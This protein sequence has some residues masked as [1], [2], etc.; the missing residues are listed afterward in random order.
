MNLDTCTAPQRRV[1][2]TLNAPLMVSAGAG[3]GKTFTL[4]QRVAY[5]LSPNGEGAAYLDSVDELLAITFTTKAAAELKS[6]IKG[7]LLSEGLAEEALKVDGAWVSTIH[8]MASRILREHALEIGIDPAFEVVG[9]VEAARLLDAATEDVAAAMEAGADPALAAL[10]GRE[11]LRGSAPGER[12]ALDFARAVLDRVSALPGGFDALVDTGTEVRPADLVRRALAA[13]EAMAAYAAGWSK[14]SKKKVEFADRLAGAIEGAQAWLAGARGDAFA[15]DALDTDGLC[16]VFYAFPLT[17]GCRVAE[18]D[19]AA[20]EDWQATLMELERELRAGLGARWEA[21]VI[22]LARAVQEAYWT[23]KG[24]SRL[25]NGDLLELAARAL[26]EHPSIAGALR[27]RFKIIMVDEFQDTDRVQVDIIGRIAQPGF[28]NV[29]TV[30]DAQQS[31]YRFRGADVNVFTEYRDDLAARTGGAAIERLDWNF[32]SHGDVLALVER[33]FAQPTVFGED[34]LR[35]AAKGK[36]AGEP[37]EV[38]DGGALPRVALSVLQRPHRGVTTDAARRE[39]ARE[40]ADR[41]AALRDAGA[42]VGD[43]VLLLGK[44]SGAHVYA[45]ALREAGIPSVIAGGSVFATLPEPQLVAALLRWAANTGDDAALYAVLA[46]PLFAVSDD[47]LLVLATRRDEEGAPHRRRLSAGLLNRE[48]DEA[49]AAEGLPA[50]DRA[51]AAEARRLLLAFARAARTD[52]PSAALRALLLD[53]GLLDRLSDEGVDGVARGANFAKAVRLVAEMEAGA[54]GIASLASAFDAHLA[55]AKEAPGALAGEDGDYVRIMT[56][57]AS[58]G[59]EFPHVA[60]ADLKDGRESVGRLAVE[61]IGNAALAAA[62]VK[63]EGPCGKMVETYDRQAKKL[64][65]DGGERAMAELTADVSLAGE[66]FA[67]MSPGRRYQALSAYAKDQALA[68]ARRLLYVALTR[69]SKSLFVALSLQGEGEAPYEKGGVAA[70]LHDALGWTCEGER[71]VT[72][73]DYGGTA[74]AHVVYRFLRP[75]GEE[76]GGESDE[77]AVPQSAEIAEPCMAGPTG[78]A[79]ADAASGSVGPAATARGR[80]DADAS[81][82]PFVVPERERYPQPLLMPKNLAREDVYS[83]TSIAGAASHDEFYEPAAAPVGSEPVHPVEAAGGEGESAIAAQSGA[84]G[85]T[86][87]QG[88]EEVPASSLGGIGGERLRPESAP[89]VS[90][91]V[92]SESATA[93]GTAFHRLAQQAI[94]RSTGGALFHPGEAAIAAQIE[95]EGLTPAQ[96]ERLRTAL[97]RWFASDEAARFAARIHRGAEVPFTVV[98]PAPGVE[99]SEGALSDAAPHGSASAASHKPGAEV[100]EAPVFYL[101]GEIDGLADNDDGRALLIDYKT[102]GRPDETPEELDAKHRL[103]ASCYAYALLRAGYD[104]VDAHFLRIE[105]TSPDNPRDPQIVPYHFEQSELGALE[106]LIMQKQREAAHGA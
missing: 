74:P 54:P 51:A 100:A 58:K 69:A 44:M 82:V 98:L 1:V 29:C 7:L 89:D 19:A 37:D 61:N 53:A 57:H 73:A 24:P 3:S 87:G 105:H 84:G 88:A 106:A 101:E 27:E 55:C 79:S 59:L 80:F 20:F 75:E 86:D 15:D 71:S 16:A 43:M 68:E 70:D 96:Q 46:S 34:F 22:A 104:S 10:L 25:D 60:V 32:R 14:P 28:A 90:A 83:Y 78:T 47:V 40:V 93:L 49:L 4:T 85:A 91:D 102:G 13:G 12:G 11:K 63:P 2:T 26:A 30:G 42:R 8:G 81:F 67:A 6:R 65:D 52:S 45:A 36:V 33:V 38:F 95:K 76:V 99:R 31:I 56:V 92:A 17:L 35:L 39:V 103:Q 23:R 94:E 18:A 48:M 21:G 5:A 97:S 9:E 62:S 64:E 72:E 41:F 77:I 50:N 66:V